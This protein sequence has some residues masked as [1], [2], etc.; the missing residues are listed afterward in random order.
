M[1]CV[2]FQ[3]FNNRDILFYFANHNQSGSTN[4]NSFFI[5]KYRDLSIY[6]GCKTQ[7]HDVS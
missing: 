5:V 1:S 7:V 6:S 2:F 3:L 4:I